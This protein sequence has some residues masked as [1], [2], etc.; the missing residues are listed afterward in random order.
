MVMQNIG[1][2]MKIPYSKYIDIID[3]IKMQIVTRR[4]EGAELDTISEE[5]QLSHNHICK[6]LKEKMSAEEREQ[7]KHTHRQG[8]RQQRNHVPYYMLTNM[9]VLKRRLIR[10]EMLEP[11]CCLCGWDYKKQDLWKRLPKDIQQRCIPIQ[12]DHIDSDRSNNHLSNL[13][14]LCPNCHA[15]QETSFRRKTKDFKPK[16]P[17][18]MYRTSNRQMAI[19]DS[20]RVGRRGGFTD[21]QVIAIRLAYIDGA[22]L[23]ELAKQYESNHSTLGD[24]VRGNSYK[25]LL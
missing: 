14:L 10:L 21:A 11:I 4:K 1:I 16:Y 2:D 15:L 25:Y 9:H 19:R 13:R 12:L 6:V 3:S 17:E 23:C 5:F 22:T 18:K 7:F 8:N 20:R 24:M